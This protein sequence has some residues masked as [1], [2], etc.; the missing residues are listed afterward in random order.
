MEGW[1]SLF[2]NPRDF[3]KSMLNSGILLA[4]GELMLK[5]KTKSLLRRNWSSSLVLQ[6]TLSYGQYN[7]AIQATVA[8]FFRSFY[9]YL[10]LLVG[11]LKLVI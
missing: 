4:H 1:K 11:H 9:A 6:G 7:S 8:F 2:L 5:G 3:G 10:Y